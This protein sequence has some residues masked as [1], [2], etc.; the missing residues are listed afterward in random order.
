MYKLNIVTLLIFWF[1]FTNALADHYIYSIHEAKDGRV[2]FLNHQTGDIYQVTENGLSHLSEGT[3]KL[4]IGKYFEVETKQG[5]SKFLKY[6][7]NTKFEK[8]ISLSGKYPNSGEDRG[9]RS[10]KESLHWLHCPV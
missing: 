3:T 7:G 8:T 2:F 5:D 6:I 1:I 9:V 10:R 4:R